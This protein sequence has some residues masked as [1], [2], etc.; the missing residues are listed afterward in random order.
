MH[1]LQNVNACQCRLQGSLSLDTILKAATKHE[2][3]AYAQ[4]LGKTRGLD[5]GIGLKTGYS[6]VC[7][8]AP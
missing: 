4:Q 1:T 6:I 7:F 8:F 2:D 3:G 5:D